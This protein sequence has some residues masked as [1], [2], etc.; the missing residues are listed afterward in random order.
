MLEMRDFYDVDRTRERYLA[1]IDAKTASLIAFAAWLGAHLAGATRDE[2]ARLERYGGVL[3][4]AFQLADDILDL[5]GNAEQT[6]KIPGADL[7]QG[8]YTLPVIEAVGS[9]EGLRERLLEGVESHELPPLV[10]RI[11]VGGAVEMAL[12]ECNAW[13]D[14]AIAILP[15]PAAPTECEPPLVELSEGLRARL[16]EAGSL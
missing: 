1:A 8:I 6:G 3:G 14:E 4:R 2:Q 10:E 5:V 12:E 7:R 13:I 16:P 9:D 15:R 11:R